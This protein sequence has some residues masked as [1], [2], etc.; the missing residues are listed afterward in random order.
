[1]TTV[2]SAKPQRAPRFRE[3]LSSADQTRA[4]KTSEKTAEERREM[5]RL[6]MELS[7][8]GMI[9]CVVFDVVGLCGWWL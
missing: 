3:A 9:W 4:Q 2:V 6:K 8:V 7:P 5:G 1:M